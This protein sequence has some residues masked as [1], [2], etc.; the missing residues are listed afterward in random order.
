MAI[1]LEK[2][3]DIPCEINIKRQVHVYTS[4]QGWPHDLEESKV[5][6][7]GRVPEQLRH[8]KLVEL[9]S[10]LSK[11]GIK[12]WRIDI[13]KLHSGYHSFNPSKLEQLKQQEPDKLVYQVTITR[14]E[15]G[16]YMKKYNIEEAHALLPKPPGGDWGF[17][18]LPIFK[19]DNVTISLYTFMIC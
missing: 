16:E 19:D 17:S 6:S 11:L 5:W 3:L 13:I 4:T 7:L 15:F 14:S 2:A 12:P 10:E 8:P 9:V 18:F 1:S